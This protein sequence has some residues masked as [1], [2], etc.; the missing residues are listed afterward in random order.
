MNATVQ[1]AQIHLL[2][3][4]ASWRVRLTELGLES[5]IEF[6]AWLAEDPAHELAW[7]RVQAPWAEIGNQAAS[8]EL[9]ELRRDALDRARSQGRQ[10]WRGHADGTRRR[11]I[12]AAVAVLVAVVA[13]GVV[14]WERSQ[15]LVYRTAL[16]ERRVVSLEDGS[17]LSL[18]SDS[19]VRVRLR[20][21][22]R[23][24]ELRRGQARFDVAH[25]AQRPFSVRA[26][27]Q[28][29]IAT[30]TAFNI[31]L[32]GAGVV[33]TLIEGSVVVTPADGDA[34]PREESAPVTLSAGQQLIAARAEPRRVAKVRLDHATSWETGELVFED[35]LLGTVAERVSR[36]SGT[37][38]SVDANARALRISGVFKTG[39]VATFVEM[40]TRYLPVAAVTQRDSGILLRSKS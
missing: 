27:D 23:R 35:A 20:D 17:R 29:V 31:D 11:T 37:K 22:A 2:A 18:D 40:V 26:R 12:A 6:E 33:V 4:A 3:A 14:Q 21:E 28:T 15:E 9:M 1:E 24:L 7:A 16:G 36:Y 38:V 25:D 10:R 32:A 39:D 30:G 19:E 34:A 13:G 8:P 5:T